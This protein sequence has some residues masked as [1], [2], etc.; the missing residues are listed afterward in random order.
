MKLRLKSNGK[1]SWTIEVGTYKFWYVLHR[2]ISFTNAYKRY[3]ELIHVWKD[4][5]HIPE[6]QNL[7]EDLD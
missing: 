5:K 1:G 4:E 6:P 7:E 3:M 2:D